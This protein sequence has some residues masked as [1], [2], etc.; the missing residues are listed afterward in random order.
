MCALERSR[1]LRG[2][3]QQCRG[4]R[5][6]G[7]AGLA[8][9]AGRMISGSGQGDGEDCRNDCDDEGTRDEDGFAPPPRP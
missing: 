9:L 6:G 7:L 4:V 2:L 3:R 8:G 5:Q 1:A